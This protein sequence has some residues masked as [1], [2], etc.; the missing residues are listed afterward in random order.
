[1]LIYRVSSEV[2]STQIMTGGK[3]CQELSEVTATRRMRVIT[4]WRRAER[5]RESCSGAPEFGAGC[6]APAQRRESVGQSKRRVATDFHRICN[7]NRFPLTF[8][9]NRCNFYTLEGVAL[10]VRS[11]ENPLFVFALFPL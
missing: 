4:H 11:L 7:L 9:D 1:M 2:P 5:P 3:V 10:L 6:I 8:I